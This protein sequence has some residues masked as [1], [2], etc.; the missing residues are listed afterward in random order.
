MVIKTLVRKHFLVKK[1]LSKKYGQKYFGLKNCQN[2]NPTT[3]QPNLT[4]VWVLRENDFTPPPPP[5][6]THHPKLNVSN[7]SAVTCPILTKL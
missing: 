3:T 7:I 4:Y 1:K 6:P 2:P 5:P